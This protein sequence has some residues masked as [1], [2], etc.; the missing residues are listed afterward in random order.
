ME[1]LEKHCLKRLNKILYK[2]NLQ[3]VGYQNKYVLIDIQENRIISVYKS[4]NEML[5]S[6]LPIFP[7]LIL[8]LSAP[9][10]IDNKASL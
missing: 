6:S 10:A 3:V 4:I 2:F 9:L 5:F 1:N 8:I 7:G